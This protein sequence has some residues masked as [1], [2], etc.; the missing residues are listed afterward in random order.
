MRLLMGLAIGS[1]TSAERVAKVLR[2]VL[3]VLMVWFKTFLAFN[4]L[5]CALI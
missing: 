2:V 5:A 1:I 3:A 4:Y